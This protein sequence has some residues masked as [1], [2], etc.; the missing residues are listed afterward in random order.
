[1]HLDPGLT[2]CVLLEQ[3]APKDPALIQ[4]FIDVFGC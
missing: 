2:D 3:S 4:D 1:M